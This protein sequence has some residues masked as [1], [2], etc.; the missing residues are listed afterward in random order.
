MTAEPSSPRAA[1]LDGQQGQAVIA[2]NAYD[3]NALRATIA[4]MGAEAVIPS[5]RSRKIIIPHDP[6]VYRHRNKIGRCF[7]RLKHFRRVA[8]RWLR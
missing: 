4:S 2:D 3:S 1:I 6:V 8:T 5:N 7:H